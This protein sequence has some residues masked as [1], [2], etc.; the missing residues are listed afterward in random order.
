MYKKTG[1]SSF[2]LVA[3]WKMYRSYYATYAW[4]QEHL[5]LLEE[6]A[7][8]C[9]FILCPEFTVLSSVK[10]LFGPESSIHV[11]AQNCA[12]QREGPY[13]GEVSVQS[14]ADIGC[15]HCLVG[16][17]ERR[18]FESL[19]TISNKISL[20]L[21]AHIIPI[22]CLG[23]TEEE[24]ENEGTIDV[25]KN[26]ME[27]I[28]EALA[29]HTPSTI[30]LY[31]A[32][33]PRWAIGTGKIPSLD[34]LTAIYQVLADYQTILAARHQ[35]LLLYGGSVTAAHIAWLKKIPALQG[36]LLGSSSLDS[37]ELKNIVSLV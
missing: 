32:Y 37:Q 30:P 35:L 13:T 9:R 33:E 2:T 29:S 6:V 1:S 5:A 10:E 31:I 36:F 19:T 27:A 12:S 17:S 3:N 24:K 15:T 14:L 18:A 16:H 21:D 4:C 11:G 22:V 23:E 8:Q 28:I 34:Y 20:L 26:N 7:H 25:I